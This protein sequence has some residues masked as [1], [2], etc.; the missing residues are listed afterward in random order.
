MEG[1]CVVCKSAL[2]D[3]KTLWPGIRQRNSSG[4]CTADLDFDNLR[5]DQIYDASYFLGD[6]YENYLRNR[7]VFELLL[8]D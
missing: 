4:H 2:I 1:S 6:E 3:G 8:S 5:F 7:S